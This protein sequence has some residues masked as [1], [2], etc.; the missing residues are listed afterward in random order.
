[1]TK[2]FEIIIWITISKDC[3]IRK[4]QAEIAQRFSLQLSNDDSNESV[5]S[6][7]FQCLTGKKFL[8]LMDDVWDKVDL[9][10][11]GIP[12]PNQKNGCKVV[13]TTRYR[14]VCHKMKTDEEIKV[15]SCCLRRKLGNCFVKQ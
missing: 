13:L 4:L 11:I 9:D 2:L 10:D 12:C 7:L 15:W 8:L 1:M 14:D 6:K 5:A 3:S